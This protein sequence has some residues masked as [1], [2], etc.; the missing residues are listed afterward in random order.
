MTE[1]ISFKKEAILN[2]KNFKI[3][4]D[5]LTDVLE[6]D[7]LEEYLTT[8]V[9]DIIQKDV[10]KTE[11][12]INKAK[13]NNSKVRYIIK[14]TINSKI[15]E[16]ILGMNTPLAIITYL[17]G[18]YGGDDTDMTQWLNKLKKEKSKEEEIPTVLKR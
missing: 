17:K 1:L 14:N 11:E 12:D 6:K 10:T 3:W 7:G 18:E 2:D 9:V 15:H 8:D 13:K 4:Y 5:N 16:D